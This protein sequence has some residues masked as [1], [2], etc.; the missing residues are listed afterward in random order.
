[1]ANFRSN[2][3]KPMFRSG[4]IKFDHH[5]STNLHIP[6]KMKLDIDIQKPDFANSLNNSDN[7]VGEHEQNI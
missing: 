1:M 6:Q 5:S 2:F 7:N 4:F 3:N